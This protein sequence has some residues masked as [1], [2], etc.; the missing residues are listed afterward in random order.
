MLVQVREPAKWIDDL[1]ESPAHA[2]VFRNNCEFRHDNTET[3]IV[4]GNRAENPDLL[5][6]HYKGGMMVC[7]RPETFDAAAEDLLHHRVEQDPPWSIEDMRDSTLEE[8]GRPGMFCN[9]TPLKFWEALAR[10]GFEVKADDEVVAYTWF[11]TGEPRFAELVSHP[12]RLGQGTELH[13][14]VRQGISYDP[15]G[16]Y[17]KMCLEHGPSFVCEVD[18]EPVC[19]SATHLNGTM[20]MIYTP[21]EHRRKGYARSLAAFQIDY[22][23]RRDGL[24]CC[25]II[26][27]NTPS[28]EMIKTFG[29]KRAGSALVWRMVHWP[30]EQ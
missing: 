10:A 3:S 6:S 12:C 29:F 8:P 4:L 19:W 11:T 9:S 20:A 1:S 23:L 24:A 16:V 5:I 15:E 22:M 17:T 26:S 28:N 7:G 27:T 21:D 14:Y 18:G 25:H 13:Q 2:Y 30:D